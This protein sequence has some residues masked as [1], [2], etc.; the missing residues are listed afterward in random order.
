VNSVVLVTAGGV[1]RIRSTN[2]FIGNVMSKIIVNFLKLH[3]S[4]GHFVLNY[5]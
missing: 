1:P 3:T 4:E 5:L 2:S